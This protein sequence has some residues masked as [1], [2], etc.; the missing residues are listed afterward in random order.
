MEWYPWSWF[1][2]SPD[3]ARLAAGK[4]PY[5]LFTTTLNPQRANRWTPYRVPTI[6]VAKAFQSA[7]H[8]SAARRGA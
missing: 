6:E 8:R 1:I 3:F 7:L 2:P 5:L 4:G